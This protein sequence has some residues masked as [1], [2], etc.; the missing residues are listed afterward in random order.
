MLRLRDVMTT[1]VATLDSGSSV[2]DAMELLA[3]HHISG[4]PV[5]EGRRVV[6]V[7][8]ATDLLAF[9]AEITGGAA[10]G[11]PPPAVQTEEEPAGPDGDEPLASWFTTMWDDDGADAAV[12]FSS[13]RGPEWNL[14]EQHTV[15][16]V[17]TAGRLVSLPS[18]ALLTEAADTMT[19]ESIHRILVMDGDRLLGI[20]TASDINKMA[21]EGK[22]GKRVYTFPTR[23][24]RDWGE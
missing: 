22:L 10:P 6:G 18:T 14:L 15:A 16:E 8:S 23:D 9:A 1:D 3:R 5:V 4:A 2:R 20:V 17:M 24:A 19:R 21:A 7:V 11:E 12:R 13:A